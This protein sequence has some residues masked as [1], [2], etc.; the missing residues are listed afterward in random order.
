MHCNSLQHFKLLIE[1]INEEILKT[2]IDNEII[3]LEFLVNNDYKI[4][5]E[6]PIGP[7]SKDYEKGGL[8]D[9]IA[10]SS[11]ECFII[12]NKVDAEDQKKQLIR[13]YNYIVDHKINGVLIY[14]T[15]YGSNPT[16]KSI[17][18]RT[19][20][21]YIC[22]SY[23]YTIINWLHK[24]LKLYK[25]DESIY[26]AICQ[27]IDVCKSITGQFGG[28]EMNNEILSIICKNDESIISSFHIMNNAI[29]LKKNVI[30]KYFIPKIRDSLN[31]LTF[32]FEGIDKDFLIPSNRVIGDKWWG[33]V[34]KKKDEDF[35]N[36]KIRF[37]FE[38]DSFSKMNCSLRLFNK[39]DNNIFN[40]KTFDWDIKCFVDL[41]KDDDTEIIRILNDYIRIKLK[42]ANE[43]DK[44]CST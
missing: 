20:I 26:K 16:K 25:A 44:K 43:Y 10:Y 42:E 23:K 32:L 22:I 5:N 1:T 39:N 27:Y 21:P 28:N 15:K 12:E 7:I 17:E 6:Y 3:Q 18:L 14:L 24:C 40:K 4:K 2:S 30:I 33:F 29:E 35:K 41:V 19:D 13:Y 38:D 37:E 36:V 31:D 34:V 11:N 8:I 9:L